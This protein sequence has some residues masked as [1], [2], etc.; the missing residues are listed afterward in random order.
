MLIG[1][2]SARPQTEAEDQ[3]GFVPVNVIVH[4]STG[5]EIAV[6]AD[7]IDIRGCLIGPSAEAVCPTGNIGAAPNERV[8]FRGNKGPG[9]TGSNGNAG[10]VNEQ[11]LPIDP[12]AETYKKQIEAYQQWELQQAANNERIAALGR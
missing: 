1:S 2:V 3:G 5:E 10:P 6:N 4:Y 9:L 7:N 11:G 8:S 12:A